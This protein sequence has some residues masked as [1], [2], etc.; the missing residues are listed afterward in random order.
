MPRSRVGFGDSLWARVIISESQRSTLFHTN[1]APQ[2]LRAVDFNSSPNRVMT[3]QVSPTHPL[4][5]YNLIFSTQW[6]LLNDTAYELRLRRQIQQAAN[7]L[8]DFSD[9]QISLGKIHIFQNYDGW[10][11]ADV[12]IYASN[13]LR[14]HASVG[15]VS[16]TEVAD[17]LIANVSYYPGHTFMG[18]TWNRFNLPG[19]PDGLGVDISNDWPLALAHELSHYLLYL[20]DTYLALTPE[21]EIVET[22]SCT[23]SAMG[24]VYEEMNTEFVFDP[25]HWASACGDT[26][27][28]RTLKRTEWQT[29]LLWYSSLL[30]PSTVNPG[31][32]APP[33]PLVTTTVH[34]PSNTAVV[35]PNQT[36]AL[37]Y[38]AGEL[39]SEEAR[40]F[41]IRNNHII[42]QGKPDAASAQIT[43]VGA[44]TDDRFC[45]FDVNDFSEG[46]ES[47]RHQY[48]CEVLAL[49]DNT[50]EMEKD[51]GWAPIIQISHAAS[52]TIGISVTQTI[53]AGLSL[54][55]V[56]YPEDT[57]T[58][59]EILLTGV[60]DL[61]TGTFHSPVD[62]TAAYVQ[63]YVDEASSETDPRR[64]TLVD[65]GVGGGGAQGPTSMF[66]GVPIVSSDGKAEFARTTDIFLEK[67]EFM[68]LQS[69]A[70]TPRPPEGYQIVGQAYRL[71]ALPSTLADEGHVTLHVRSAR[72]LARRTQV[73]PTVV[74]AFWDSTNWTPLK[75]VNLDDLIEGRVAIAPSQGVGV[76]AL[77]LADDR[78]PVNPLYL[79]QIRQ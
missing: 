67:G 13:N 78:P 58:P 16:P 64:E 60:G 5:L 23:G 25:T 21:G 42:D 55:A 49:G 20:F 66:G 45:V 69:M 31:P 75:S 9:G 73:L 14:P 44:Q 50:L 46:G 4:L 8:Y 72:G 37:N 30:A 34:P 29:I 38:Q 43:L 77:L 68:A 35:L 63:I 32:T 41:L 28:N 36:F 10:D 11:D 76:Y 54:R 3:L 74:V 24:W 70:G 71:V 18:R 19:E 26:L 57:D 15:G 62:A 12:R 47:P 65:Y 7:Y 22:D 6:S 61:Y 56:L 39:A 27:A 17:P 79:P 48:G 1:G 59:T 53:E 40:A 52:R 51:D 2:R 33:T